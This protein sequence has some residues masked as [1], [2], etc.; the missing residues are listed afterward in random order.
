MDRRKFIKGAAGLF[1]PAAPALLLPREARAMMN[2]FFPGPGTV[3]TTGGAFTPA[4]IS[5]LVAWYKADVGVTTSSGNVSAWAD[6]GGNGYNLSGTPVGG[7]SPTVT[8]GGLNGLDILNWPNS[9]NGNL[10]TG[11]AAVTLGGTGSQASVFVVMRYTGNN[12]SRVVSYSVGGSDTAANAFISQ[13]VSASTTINGFSNGVKGA[14]TT[15]NNTWAQVGSIF[16]G[17]NNT[18]YLNNVAGTPVSSTNSF[19]ATGGLNV[20]GTPSGG[21]QYIGDIAE[22]VIYNVAL[23]GTDR[24]NLAAYFFARWGV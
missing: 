21:N 23:T 5:G 2:S 16:D 8:A 4:S 14:L 7:Q 9:T 3:H 10:S 13:F 11:A 15:T 1:V 19:S 6:Q 22:I 24:S 18:L 17:T 12:N 20:G